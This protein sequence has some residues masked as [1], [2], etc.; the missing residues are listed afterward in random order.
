MKNLVIIL[1]TM[2]VMMVSCKKEKLTPEPA[3]TP[4]PTPI[5]STDTCNCATWDLTKVLDVKWYYNPTGTSN[6]DSCFVE[7][8]SDGTFNWRSSTAVAYSNPNF[9]YHSG[10]WEFNKTKK[11]NKG[12]IRK[13]SINIHFSDVLFPNAEFHWDVTTLFDSPFRLMMNEANEGPNYVFHPIP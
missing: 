9:K 13:C 11:D 10:T 1:A 7:F 3:P 5:V 2:M 4:D 8:K 6:G 12:N